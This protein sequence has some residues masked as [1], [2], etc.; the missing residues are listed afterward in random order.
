MYSLR[1]RLFLAFIL[2]ILVTIGTV[3]IFVSRASQIEI[4]QYQLRMKQNQQERIACL[5]SQYGLHGEGWADVQPA[6]QHMQAVFGQH[7]IL[8]DDQGTVVAD[9]LGEHLGEKYSPSWLGNGQ[10]VQY[11]QNSDGK[12]G[13]LYTSPDSTY[14]DSAASILSLSDSIN[15]FLL[16]GGALAIMVALAITFWL[17]RR[18]SAPIHAL[19]IAN[20]RIGEG[21]FSRRLPF[22]GKDEV[23]ELINSFNS[24]ADRLK[25]AE[26]IRRDLVAD[27]A[28][29]LRAPVSSIRAYLEAMRDGLMDTNTKSLDSLYE[30]IILL[31]RLIDDLQT[32]SLA[33]AG[34]LSLVYQPEDISHIVNSVAESVQPKAVAKRINLTVNFP[35]RLPPTKVDAQRLS[36][37]LHNLLDNAIRHTP[38]G[39][40][41]LVNIVETDKSIKVTVSD[42][43]EGIPP[44]DLPHMFERFYRV[45]KSRSKAT[46][47]SGL[48]LTIARR[49]VEAHGGKI[50]VRSKLG[51]GSEFTFT[52]P[53]LQDSDIKIPATIY[54]K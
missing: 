51:E 50:E 25:E 54:H 20:K 39:G 52:I 9:S 28:H 5:L 11:I 32:L 24:M 1:L 14:V 4:E 47:G 41:V 12:P 45:D 23:G 7:I 43:G 37:I 22:W 3:S 53:V 26:Q 13:T 17:S 6:V 31:S 21:D 34:Q 42:T 30:D 19:T 2:V 16:W 35:E 44:E 33:D 36:Q 15:R 40:S 18:I 10:Q 8:A 38:S 48:G 27:V 49:L 29:E 46:G